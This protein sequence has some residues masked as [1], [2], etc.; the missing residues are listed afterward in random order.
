MADFLY[1]TTSAKFCIFYLEDL[2]QFIVTCCIEILIKSY[3]KKLNKYILTVHI[4]YIVIVLALDFFD[5]DNF[6]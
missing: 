4:M 6:G 5:T 1:D 2:T 3:G